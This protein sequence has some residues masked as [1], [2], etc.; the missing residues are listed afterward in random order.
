MTKKAVTAKVSP[1]TVERLEEWA[2]EK[3]ISR[4]EATNRLLDKALDIEENDKVIVQ[5]DGGTLIED[6]LDELEYTQQKQLETLEDTQNVIQDRIASEPSRLEKGIELGYWW[7]SG[8]GLSTGLFWLLARYGLAFQNLNLDLSY[9]V[10]MACF[11]VGFSFLAL[12]EVIK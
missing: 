9:W 1:N 12:S 11:L 10:S 4:S 5:T 6:R 7:F 8:L 3:D 2:E